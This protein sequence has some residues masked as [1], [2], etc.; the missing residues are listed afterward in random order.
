MLDF[1]LCV[2]KYFIRLLP[3]IILIGLEPGILHIYG[4]ELSQPSF[5]SSP[6]LPANCLQPPC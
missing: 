3:Q 6:P 4:G 2:S 1:K 5:V